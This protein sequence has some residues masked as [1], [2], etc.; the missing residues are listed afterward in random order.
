VAS[1]TTDSETNAVTYSGI[2]PYNEFRAV[3]H[4]ALYSTGT[5]SNSLK[6]ENWEAGKTYTYH[7]GSDALKTAITVTI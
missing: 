1:E 6:Q 5:I 7:Y 2:T 3:A 4:A